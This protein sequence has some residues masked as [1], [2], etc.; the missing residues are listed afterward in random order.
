MNDHQ[1]LKR[2]INDFVDKSNNLETD[3]RI[4]K[5]EDKKLKAKR[6]ELDTNNY[7]HMIVLWRA[8]GSSVTALIHKYCMITVTCHCGR[9]ILEYDV[10]WK[11]GYVEQKVDKNFIKKIL[12]VAGYDTSHLK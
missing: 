9:G 12:N 7:V 6:L 10:R 11:N 2:E 4:H 5:N 8:Q 3:E 1:S